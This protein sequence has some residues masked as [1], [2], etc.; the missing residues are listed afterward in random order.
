[1][2]RLTGRFTNGEA[3]CKNITYASTNNADNRTFV[4]HA[5]EKLAQYEEM[6]DA[7]LL[8][9]LPCKVGDIVWYKGDWTSVQGLNP[10]KITNV[11]ISQN[12][13]GEWT[14][15][16]RAMLVRDGKTVDWQINFSFDDIDKTVFLNKEK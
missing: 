15:K 13:K 16:Y 3:Y 4:E 9:V 14:K 5:I 8:L 10:Y 12:K 7:G 6:E 1:M 2:E 11:M